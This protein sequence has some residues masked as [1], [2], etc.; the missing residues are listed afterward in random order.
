MIDEELEHIRAEKMRKM[1]DKQLED[2]DLV[3]LVIRSIENALRD[4]AI[5]TDIRGK[6]LN[7]AIEVCEALLKDGYIYLEGK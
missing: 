7:T 3:F 6:R 4:G 2:T 5:H 1:M